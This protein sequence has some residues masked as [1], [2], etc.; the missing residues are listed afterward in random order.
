MVFLWNKW[1]Y[2][3]SDV[4]KAGVILAAKKNNVVKF[5]KK[6]NINIGLIIF[7][8]IFI[9]VVISV[10]IYVFS[11]KTNIYEVTAGSLTQDNTYTGFI[12]RDEKLVKSPHSGNVNYFLGNGE[13]A[14]I[15]TIV[16][17]VDETGRVHD[18]IKQSIDS[19]LDSKE[20]KHIKDMLTKYTKEYS[21][22]N[23]YK[24]YNYKEDIASKIY[25]F[26]NND[27]TDH[28]DEFIEETG[29]DNLFHII[30]AD[31]TGI[32]SYI[33]DGYE[34][35]DET[36]IS[37]DLFDAS[38][39][40]SDNLQNSVL[41]NTN[42]VAYKIIN[43]DIWYIYIPLNV[44]EAEYYA[45]NNNINIEF[46]NNNITYEANMEVVNI[47]G[48][49]YGKIKMTKY[50]VNFLQDRYVQFKIK[51]ANTN[52]LKI[53]V[54]AVFEKSFY[55]IPKKFLT[56]SGTFMKK[57]FDDKGNVVIKGIKADIYEEND[58]Y[59]Y[60]SMNDF[61]SGDIIMLTDSD[62]TYIVGTME[63]LTGVYCVNRGY[64]VFRKVNILEENSEY[65]I[66]SK[67][68][69]YGLSIYDHI[70]LDYSTANENEIIH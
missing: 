26:Q 1:Y 31:E 29:S 2:I 41:I 46:V 69:K 58:T 47:G 43:N 14:S 10:L 13:R 37:K 49:S 62:E 11:K 24:L 45:N 4:K 59:Y 56:P 61:E 28:L 30:E 57:Y 67:G 52:G 3:E 63:E 22:S 70:V 44:N 42:D 21:Q 7:A 48:E 18:K 54:T 34:N 5:Y 15:G 25:E 68:T 50:M 51:T 40:S 8:V 6:S 39:Y 16:Y 9:Y 17:S 64:A 23:F 32:V 33:I 12:L 36:I 27:I 55:T 66:I 60:V 20:I 65:C 38:A 35:S 53:P 19:E